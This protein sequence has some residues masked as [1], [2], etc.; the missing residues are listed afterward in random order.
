MGFA[1]SYDDIPF[2]HTTNQDLANKLE[3]TQKYG[4]V[5]FRDFDEGNKFLL[6]DNALNA[7]QMKQFLESHRHPF[8]SE[9]D[10]DAANRIFGSQQDAFIL[11]SDDNKHSSVEAFKQFAKEN[12]D[13]KLVF[14]T[15]AINS[16]F[17][18]RLAEYIGVKEGPT[19]RLISFK[20][21][22]LVKYV[23]DDLTAE[24]LKQALVDF[25]DGKLQ[26]HY[27]SAK[28]PT[29]NDEPVKV[30]VGDSFEEL[31]LNDKYVLL[32][33]YAP[34]CGHCKSLVP[35]YN[36]L[37]EKLAGDSDIVIAKMDATENEHP[38]MPVTGFPTIRLF[39]PNSR[40]PVDY[41]GDRS[42]KD[43]VKFLEKQTGRALDG[44][45]SDELWLI[46]FKKLIF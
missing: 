16:G 40:S 46:N 3:I 28:A 38:L 4:F 8:V 30:V 35:I 5:L 23:V 7:Q 42:L 1:A 25:K 13:K 9:F 6:N 14:T 39:K 11:M 37:A 44:I 27:K 18:K 34:W 24:G 29:S 41:S 17:G 36:E 26:A 15:S 12:Q 21:K 32:E 31:V 2:A 20:G 43:L 22:N 33:A 45:K 10:Q 19:A